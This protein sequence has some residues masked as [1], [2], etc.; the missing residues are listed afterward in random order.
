M[1]YTQASKLASRGRVP[2][3]PGVSVTPKSTGFG[4]VHGGL[5]PQLA[6]LDLCVGELSQV[7]QEMS[8]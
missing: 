2:E 8:N 4:Q 3:D 1:S 6:H 7:G 5:G